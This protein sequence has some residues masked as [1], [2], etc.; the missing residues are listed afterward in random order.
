[1][2]LRVIRPAFAN[3]EAVFAKLVS[4]DFVVSVDGSAWNS[5]TAFTVGQRAYV[6]G[7]TN[8]LYEC[9]VAHT[10][11]NPPATVAG[12]TTGTVYWAEVSHTNPYRMFDTI[13]SSVSTATG[14]ASKTVV[15]DPGRINAIFIGNM[16]GV[17]GVDIVMTDGVTTVYS[18]SFSLITGTIDDWYKYWFEPIVMQEHLA[19]F[20][21]PTYG[22]ARVSVTF[23]G[24]GAMS[25]GT[26]QCGLAAT[27]G[28]VQW[29]PSVRFL[30]YSTYKTDTFGNVKITPRLPA[31]IVQAKVFVPRTD[32]SFDETNR[33]IGDLIGQIV[34][35]SF[36][37]DKY[38]SLNVLGFTNDFDH[39]LDSS[40]GSYFN[41]KV[42]GLI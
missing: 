6:A 35:W 42:Q 26:I 16:S 29:Q 21:L 7:T 13:N 20:D 24:G 39:V 28:Q 5:T 1:M 32:T 34:V 17:T 3:T 8:K 23:H 31:K 9:L 33:Q 11:Q 36:L 38:G 4:S 14:P 41:L 30:D 40:A 10:N 25:V 37:G 22:T 15:F 2:T 18:K 19:V 27:I 12:A